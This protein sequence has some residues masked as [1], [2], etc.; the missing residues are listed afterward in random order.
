MGL[1]PENATSAGNSM[2]MSWLAA[3]WLPRNQ[4]IKSPEVNLRVHE[5]IRTSAKC[6]QGHLALKRLRNKNSNVPTFSHLLHLE[7]NST[8]QFCR[9]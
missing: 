4:Q 1:P 6:E 7:C 3:T 9:N 2:W 8:A 5:I